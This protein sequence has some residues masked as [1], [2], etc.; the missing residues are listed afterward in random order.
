MFTSERPHNSSAVE[1]FI[2]FTS[3]CFSS[4][5]KIK[6]K[7]ISERL[8]L[9]SSSSSGNIPFRIGLSDS[10]TGYL[11]KL[12]GLSHVNQVILERGLGK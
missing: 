5:T 3:Q 7:W 2:G 8:L 6:A 9:S 12:Q 10:G 1:T 11:Q 4:I